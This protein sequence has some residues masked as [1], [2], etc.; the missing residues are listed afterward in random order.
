MEDWIFCLL[1]PYPM[2]VQFG[3]NDLPEQAFALPIMYCT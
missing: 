3:P 1:W 2:A